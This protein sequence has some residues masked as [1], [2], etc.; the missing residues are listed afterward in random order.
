MILKI[1]QGPVED[2]LDDNGRP[3][4]VTGAIELCVQLDTHV[5]LEELLV[6]NRLAAPYIIGCCYMDR[7]VWAIFTLEKRIQSWSYAPIVR[8]ALKNPPPLP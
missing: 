8:L 4:H 2:I 3:I 5:N 1:K 7:Y 6:C